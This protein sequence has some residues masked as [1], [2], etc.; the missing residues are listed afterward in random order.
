M[1]TAYNGSME[2]LIAVFLLA[3]S[4]KDEKFKETLK[5][6]IAFYRENKEL[7]YALA[8]RPQAAAESTP[9]REEEKA[10]PLSGESL[11]ILDEFLKKI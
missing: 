1:R 7:L 10:P 2:M 4:E 3:Y 6:V 9:E 11:R 8:G 5:Q